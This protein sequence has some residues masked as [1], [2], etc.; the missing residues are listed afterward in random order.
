M[1]SSRNSSNLAIVDCEDGQSIAATSSLTDEHKKSVELL[2]G[3]SETTGVATIGGTDAVI[4]I[5]KVVAAMAAV[6]VNG[7]SK[8]EKK[9]E[10]RAIAV[11]AVSHE[12]SHNLGLEDSE[13]PNQLMNGILTHDPAPTI[14]PQETGTIKERVK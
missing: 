8:K 9:K 11:N 10:I 12:V 5:N 4:D 3:E 1:N 14:T 13:E 7:K 6:K 2:C